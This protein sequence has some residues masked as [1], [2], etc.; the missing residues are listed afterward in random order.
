VPHCGQVLGLTKLSQV[1]R[2]AAVERRDPIVVP[3]ARTSFSPDEWDRGD[4][5]LV[6]HPRGEATLETTVTVPRAGRYGI[7]LGGSFRGSMEA[8]VDGRHAGEARGEL[9]YSRGQYEELGSAT[10]T[11]GRH[12]V[13]IHYGGSSLR[14]GSAGDAVLP[15]SSEEERGLS[16]R[17][18][19]SYAVGPLVLSTDT[20]DRPVSYVP[21]GEA[22]RLCGRPLDWV[23]ARAN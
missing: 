2:L 15:L 16:K 18:D 4:N 22:R 1:A 6:L 10:L 19:R 17:S 13:T 3:L 12:R 8:S 11:P 14:A 21:P 7:W 5:S 23:E 9:N 20:A